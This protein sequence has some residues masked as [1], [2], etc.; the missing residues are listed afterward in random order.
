MKKK[1]LKSDNKKKE[2]Y[3][4][5]F[6]LHPRGVEDIYKKFPIARL[7]PVVLLKKLFTCMPPILVA[8]IQG[9]VDEEGNKKRG[10]VISIPM[11]AEQMLTSPDVAKEQVIRAIKKAKSFGAKHVGLGAFTSVVTTGGLD[12][13]GVV[14]GVHVTNGNALTASMA[15]EGITKLIDEFK[16]EDVTVSIIGA[17]G[18]IGSAVTELLA[19]HGGFKNLYVVGRT[20]SRIELL[21]QKISL[22]PH[23][24]KAQAV[25]IEKAL[26]ESNIILSATSAHGAVVRADLIKPNTKVYDITQPKNISQDLLKRKDVDVYEGGLVQLPDGVTITHYIGAPKGTMFAC[27]AETVLLSL[28]GYPDDFCLG[29]VTSEQVMYIEKLANSYHFKPAEM[30]TWNIHT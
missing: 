7:V 26:P 5:A 21:M 11:T 28:A 15:Y 6:L 19:K 29:Q 24:T 20:L 25:T 17:T 1:L 16:D 10:V 27:M 22:H 2:Q 14:P 12:V 23:A 13:K 4:F 18:S 3:D 30:C 9:L 8:D